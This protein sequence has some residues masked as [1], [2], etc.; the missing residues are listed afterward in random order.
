MD[1]KEKESC[2]MNGVSSWLY[3]QSL[4]FRSLK[5]S[6]KLRILLHAELASATQSCPSSRCPA[7]REAQMCHNPE[8]AINTA[9]ALATSTLREKYSDVKLLCDPRQQ[10]GSCRIDVWYCI[11]FLLFITFN[12]RKHFFFLSLVEK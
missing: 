1:R 10:M 12:Q 7:K 4:Y 6:R 11:F 5:F 9:S 3:S 2:Q 8:R